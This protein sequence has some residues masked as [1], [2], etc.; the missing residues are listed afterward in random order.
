[1]TN[2]Q[3]HPTLPPMTDTTPIDD[4]PSN[5]KEF[6]F[7]FFVFFRIFGI[8]QTETEE[9]GDRLGPWSP[10]IQKKKKK[11]IAVNTFSFFYFSFI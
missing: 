3:Q 6:L 5:H 7:L 2:A 10:P 8:S 4:P 11:K 1:L 9:R